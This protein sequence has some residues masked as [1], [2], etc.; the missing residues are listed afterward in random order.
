MCRWTRCVAQCSG[1]FIIT[2]HER[3]ANRFSSSSTPSAGN[4]GVE[5]RSPPPP[6]LLSIFL[7]LALSLCQLSQFR[8]A[9]HFLCISSEF[10]DVNRV[11]D[12][13]SKEFSI[14]Q[15]CKA[16]WKFNHDFSRCR[17][18]TRVPSTLIQLD[19]C[20]SAGVRAVTTNSSPHTLFSHRIPSPNAICVGRRSREKKTQLSCHAN[21]TWVTLSTSLMSFCR[22][23][24]NV[25][26]VDFVHSS[27]QSVW[28]QDGCIHCNRVSCEHLPWPTTL[29]TSPPVPCECLRC[30]PSPR[31]HNNNNQIQN[32]QKL[33]KYLVRRSQCWLAL[34]L[35]HSIWR[36]QNPD[37]SGAMSIFECTYFSFFFL[38][39]AATIFKAHAT[40]RNGSVRISCTIFQK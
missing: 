5:F 4:L 11:R 22:G 33:I 31:V 29:H 21:V 32:V 2:T 28:V 12:F 14:S 8:F 35:P 38:F 13:P 37:S 30:L 6:L 9:L 25:F 10:G 40:I 20:Y 17:P 39:L 15:R 23:K 1:T 36:I 27:A 34:W 7:S 26:V 18:Y 16:F 19:G 3:N 24:K